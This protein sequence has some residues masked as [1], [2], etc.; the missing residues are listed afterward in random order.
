MFIL[1][2]LTQH[3]SGIIMPI[4]R[5]TDYVNSCMWSMPG[6]AG[7]SRA[8]WDVSCVHCVKVGIPNFTQCTQLVSQPARLQP[9]QPGILHMQLFTQSVL[10]TIGIMMPE[11]C[12]VNLMR[13]N[14]YTC[15]IQLVLSYPTPLN[16]YPVLA[17]F[18]FLLKRKVSE[19]VLGLSPSLP[20]KN[21]GI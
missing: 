13:I 18:R 20:H 9:A 7:C 5:R 14:I 6:C 17:T 12:C 21:A 2:R 1:I 11:T 4:V 19:N 8:G 15:G 16:V 10:L 3:V